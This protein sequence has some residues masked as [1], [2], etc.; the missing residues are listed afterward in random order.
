MQRREYISAVSVAA[1][2]GTC[3]CL[4]LQSADAQ[5][6]KIKIS[7]QD[8]RRHFIRVQV[9]RNGR[10]VYN[11]TFQIKRSSEM[12]TQRNPAPVIADKW[13][14]KSGRFTVT[15]QVDDQ[16]NSSEITLVDNDCYGLILDI[17]EQGDVAVYR[18]ALP[19]ADCE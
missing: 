1:L 18:G 8:N 7:N 12:G 15:A 5:L 10:V 19:T 4:S 6:G 2:L 9:R 3:G 14:S 13:P 11:S 16:N 17:R